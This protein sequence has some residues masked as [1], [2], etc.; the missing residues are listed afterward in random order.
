MQSVRASYFTQFSVGM[1]KFDYYEEVK[2]K[3]YSTFSLLSGLFNQMIQ[4][5]WCTER[6]RAK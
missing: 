3:V 6:G 5:I 2:W 1:R 4:L